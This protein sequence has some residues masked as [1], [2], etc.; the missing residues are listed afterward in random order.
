MLHLKLLILN[1]VAGV[2]GF[3]AFMYICMNT[4]HLL[5][6]S[7]QSP[8]WPRL[9][10]CAPLALA[11]EALLTSCPTN[12][13]GGEPNRKKAFEPRNMRNTKRNFSELTAW[14]ITRHFLGLPWRRSEGTPQEVFF[15]VT[16]AKGDFS[17]LFCSRISWF[18][19]NFSRN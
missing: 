9:A 6:R 7:P 10:W 14:L 16:H 11:G 3:P 12:D 5:R 19:V 8:R 13:G 15:T 1:N 2:A 17:V 4:N 18:A